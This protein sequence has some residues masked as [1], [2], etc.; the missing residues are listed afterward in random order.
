MTLLSMLSTLAQVRHGRGRKSGKQFR[1]SSDG[2]RVYTTFA[3]AF[4][5]IR[6]GQLELLKQ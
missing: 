1:I 2:G 5:T 3:I 4:E 6:Q